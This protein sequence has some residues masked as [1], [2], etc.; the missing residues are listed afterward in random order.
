LQFDSPYNTYIYQGLPP[1]PI[2]NPS[3]EALRAVADPADTPYY[4]FR[5]ACNGSGRHAFAVTYEEHL[6]NDCP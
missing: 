5:A 4:Y 1:G 2:D 3:I 6:G